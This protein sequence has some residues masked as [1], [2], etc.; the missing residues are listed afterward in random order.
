MIK[1]I[2]KSICY[3]LIIATVLGTLGFT[4]SIYYSIMILLSLIGIELTTDNESY[5]AIY[6]NNEQVEE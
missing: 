1:I 3:Y 4:V 6:F 2:I 5:T